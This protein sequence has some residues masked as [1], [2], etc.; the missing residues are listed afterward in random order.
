MKKILIALSALVIAGLASYTL[1]FSDTAAPN[2]SY[3][4]LAGQKQ[5][6]AALKGQ[7]VLVNFW[8]TSCSGCIEEMPQMKRMYQQF[9]SKGFTVLAVAM[10]YDA[11]NYIKA[12]VD[13]N[14]LPFM[15]T[16]DA[17]GEVAK[18]FG[19]IQ[20]TP[21]TFLID[22]QGKIIKRYVGVMDFKE[23]LQLIESNTAS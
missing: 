10:D 23:V 8:A 21:T 7:V 1:W 14:Q 15:V 12:Y 6:L 4:T 11:P 16:Y 19:E 5:D 18:A 9:K 13:K 17:K 20:L 2:V 3:T 22:R